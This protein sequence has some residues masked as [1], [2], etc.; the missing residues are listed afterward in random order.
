[1]PSNIDATQPPA[2]NPTTAAM[3]ANMAAAKAE[4]EALQ[5]RAIPRRCLLKRSSPLLT[6]FVLTAESETFIQWESAVSSLGDATGIWSIANPERLYIPAGYNRA[7]FSFDLEIAPTAGIAGPDNQALTLLKRN[8]TTI[9]NGYPWDTGLL[10]ETVTLRQHS[11]SFDIIVTPGEYFSLG[12]QISSTVNE[13]LY[14]D[15][16][17]HWLGV[18]L[19]NE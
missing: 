12:V 7:R 1:M 15:N 5:A 4:I 14:D 3:R 2:L 19:W 9:F 6:P 18:H 16:Y 10:G 8:G 13:K 17:V 11:E